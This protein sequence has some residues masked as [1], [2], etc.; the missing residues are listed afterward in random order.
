MDKRRLR[1][2]GIEMLILSVFYLLLDTG[3]DYANGDDIIWPRAIIK[4]FVMG[5]VVTAAIWF[6][7]KR[8][9]KDAVES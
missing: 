1:S 8:K 9:D 4:A 6:A 5:L 3:I 7:T 2:F